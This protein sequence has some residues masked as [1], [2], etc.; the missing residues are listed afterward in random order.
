MHEAKFFYVHCADHSKVEATKKMYK[1]LNVFCDL[2]HCNFCPKFL[3]VRAAVASLTAEAQ[4]NHFPDANED[5]VDNIIKCTEERKSLM[6]T[7]QIISDGRSMS[8]LDETFVEINYIEKLLEAWLNEAVSACKLKFVGN[9]AKIVEQ[10]EK[11]KK[12]EES[13]FPTETRSLVTTKLLLQHK[14]LVA[15]KEMTSN[16]LRF[17]ESVIL[18][19]L[20]LSESLQKEYALIIAMKNFLRNQKNLQSVCN[21]LSLDNFFRQKNKTIRSLRNHVNTIE[22]DFS[23]DTQYGELQ[24]CF[25]NVAGDQEFTSM[26]KLI[27]MLKL[28]A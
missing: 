18:H 2:K 23:E 13:Q 7:M 11:F 16:I 6:T 15:K 21:R 20:S 3:K 17:K 5:V 14:M 22:E 27:K 26:T 8:R 10:F 9:V 25:E 12:F 4:R 19:F 28:Y 1:Y 24:L